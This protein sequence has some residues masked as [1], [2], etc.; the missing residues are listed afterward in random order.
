MTIATVIDAPAWRHHLDNLGPFAS[1]DEYE[2]LLQAAPADLPAEEREYLVGYVAGLHRYSATEVE[3]AYLALRPRLDEL[4]DES[5]WT[6]QK[7]REL[8]RAL[9]AFAVIGPVSVGDHAIRR[10]VAEE[11][12]HVGGF[13][14]LVSMLLC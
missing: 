11:L 1:P 4:E 13:T 3:R 10:Q 2:A 9:R 8:R 14:D 6:R 12:G 5:A 7:T